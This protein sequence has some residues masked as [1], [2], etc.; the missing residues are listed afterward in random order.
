MKQVNITLLRKDL[1]KTV[2]N[3]KNT[4]EVEI[5]YKGKVVAKLVEVKED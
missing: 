1:F 2:E 5:T 4:G 3:L